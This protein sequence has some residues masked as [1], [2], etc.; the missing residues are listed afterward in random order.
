MLLELLHVDLF[1]TQLLVCQL[2]QMCSRSVAFSLSL[3]FITTNGPF[4]R[5]IYDKDFVTCHGLLCYEREAMG[6]H[7]MRVDTERGRMLAVQRA[8][9]AA[10]N[11]SSH[12]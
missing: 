1:I 8:E 11:S 12:Q 5:F 4:I 3:C 9:L 6:K 7:D 2:C 10:E